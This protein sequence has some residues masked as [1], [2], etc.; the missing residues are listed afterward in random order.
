MLNLTSVAGLATKVLPATLTIDSSSDVVKNSLLSNKLSSNQVSEFKETS[1]FSKE[2]SKGANQ[3]ISKLLDLVTELLGVLKS[4][5]NP[6]KERQPETNSSEPE[7]KKNSSSDS[8]QNFFSQ[9]K[10]S[11]KNLLKNTFASLSKSFG[12]SL[13]GIF[14]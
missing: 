6:V 1:L 4:S 2:E 9:I 10:D 8:W 12:Q 11:F 3:I 13:S 14:K 7:A 5:L